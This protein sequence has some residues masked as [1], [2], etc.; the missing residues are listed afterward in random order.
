MC[1][2]GACP[3]QV[4]LTTSRREELCSGVVLGRR[5]ILTAASCLFLRS[6]QDSELRPSNFLVL[7]DSNKM[8]V[9][10]RALY[11]H[12][13]Y[14]RDHHDNDLAL[15]E[16][17]TPLSFGPALIHLCLPTRDFCENI[18]MQSGRTGM[19]MKQG[20]DEVEDLVYMS[21]DECR[22]QLN[23]SHPL[24]NKMFCV[25]SLR[26]P[27]GTR[28]EPEQAQD[29]GAREE[30]N[31]TQEIQSRAGG[32]PG[33]HMSSKTQNP[34]LEEDGHSGSKVSRQHCDRRLTGTPV[35]TAEQGTVF[36]T[37]LLM[38]SSAGCDSD[39]GSLVFTKLSRYLNWIQTRL[40]VAEDHMTPQVNLYPETH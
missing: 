23:V 21:L 37:G 33:N 2:N 1:P 39:G 13:R 34:P 29:R 25:N 11:V 36:V 4:S 18:L 26:E 16:L 7:S 28:P 15:L 8:T 35:A 14:R 27:S 12:N 20:L 5:S 31:R 3:W 19:A 10:V 38:S 6:E 24:S 22:S 17:A 9:P 32:T 30:Q 40:E